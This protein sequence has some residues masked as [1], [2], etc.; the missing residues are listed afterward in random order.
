MHVTR[1]A[2]SISFDST[3]CGRYVLDGF[4]AMAGYA[5]LLRKWDRRESQGARLD[6]D[7]RAHRDA[8]LARMKRLLREGEGGNC[9]CNQSASSSNSTNSGNGVSSSGG[10]SNSEKSDGGISCKAGFENS[11][12]N[13]H[14][15]LPPGSSWV[16]LPSLLS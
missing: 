13:A 1:E 12:E 14:Q 6:E 9:V 3:G 2:N 8:H 7:A 11:C 5:A 10:S 4:A 16:M 15:R